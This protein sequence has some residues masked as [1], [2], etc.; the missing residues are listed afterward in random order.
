MLFA[1]PMLARLPESPFSAWLPTIMQAAGYSL[2]S[3]L[4]QAGAMWLGVAWVC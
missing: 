3:V 4:L 2:G 1:L